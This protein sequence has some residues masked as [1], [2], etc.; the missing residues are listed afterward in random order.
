MNTKIKIEIIEERHYI[1]G[2]NF[3]AFMHQGEEPHRRTFVLAVNESQQNYSTLAEKLTGVKSAL[4]K[5]GLSVEMTY[6]TIPDPNFDTAEDA[7]EYMNN[8]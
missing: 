3:H 2:D 1:E 6:T 4:E 5:L 8:H 7:A